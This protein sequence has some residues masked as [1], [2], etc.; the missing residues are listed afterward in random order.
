[1]SVQA[2]TLI[3]ETRPLSAVR[4]V[5][6]RL[7]LYLFATGLGAF[8][9]LPMLWLLFAPFD[10]VPTLRA[11]L[12]SPTLD[13]FRGVLENP[14]ALS[15]LRNSVILAVMTML[16]VVASSALAAYALSRVR[17]PGRDALLYTLLLFSAVVSG[18]AAMVPLFQLVFTMGLIDTFTGVVLVLAGGLL[19]A[20][21]FILKDFMDTVPTS[22]EESA[23]VAGASSLQTLRDVVAPIVRPGLA[24]IAVWALVQVWGNFLMPF[25]LLR[26][27]DL[28]PAA[29]VMFNFYNE[30]GQANLS[31]ISAYSLL[32]SVPVV[33]MYVFVNTRYGFR[34]HGGIKR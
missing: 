1:M 10:E 16:F 3:D 34:F 26:S 33:I 5:L 20:A 25:I 14:F 27:P 28:L 31:L 12:P 13:N 22:Y 18:S 21:L 8:F 30:A 2:P 9:A 32:Y 17:I 6:A 15:S 19:P 23:R 29:V 11:E 24:V 4:E 7:G